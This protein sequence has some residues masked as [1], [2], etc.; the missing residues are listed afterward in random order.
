MT[1]IVCPHCD[2]TNR[3]PPERLGDRPKCGACHRPLF[4]G[5]PLELSGG[6]FEAQV[7]RSDLPVIVDFWAPWCGPCRMM[8]PVFARV[9]SQLDTRARFAKVNTEEHPDLAARHGIRSIPTLMV[10]KQ[11][12]ERDRAAGALDERSLRAWV[13]RAL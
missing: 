13:E 4:T 11:G 2:S 8:A 10:F 9:A 12:R 5:Q 6:N 3:V 1:N 7:T